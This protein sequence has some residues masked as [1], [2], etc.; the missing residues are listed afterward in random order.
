MH[1]FTTK[2]D[3]ILITLQAILVGNDYTIIIAGGER[4][5]IGA[6]ALAQP[7]PS[8]ENPK[9]WSASTS[10]MCVLG[11]KE[12]LLAH[13]VAQTLASQLK[14]IVS[15]NCGIHMD[16]ASKAQIKTIQRLVTELMAQFLSKL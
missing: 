9:Q 2:Q 15:V 3:D 8:L 12:D 7:R 5:H 6:S 10:V 13:H 1:V 16:N 4:P 11:H 14:C